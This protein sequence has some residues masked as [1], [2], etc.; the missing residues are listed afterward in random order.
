MMDEN[1]E[2]EET[3]E[4][5][6]STPAEPLSR[7]DF[8]RRASSEA[9]KTGATLVPGGAVARAV[10]GAEPPPPNETEAEKEERLKKLPEWMRSLAKWRSHKKQ[11]KN[12]G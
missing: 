7:R 9:V 5:Q 4:T 3:K 11:E 12:A 8:L 6:P 2:N 10:L 1:N